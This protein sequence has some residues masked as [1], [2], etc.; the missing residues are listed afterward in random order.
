MS[1]NNVVVRT[2]NRIKITVA[3]LNKTCC[4]EFI[5]QDV[6]YEAVC[7]PGLQQYWGSLT[8]GLKC[9]LTRMIFF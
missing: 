2:K 1:D 6:P 9:N 5:S 3:C 4:V 8:S 7:E